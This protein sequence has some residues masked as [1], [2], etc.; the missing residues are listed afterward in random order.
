M[1]TQTWVDKA[2]G[3]NSAHIS[4]EHFVLPGYGD[5]GPTLEIFSYED[6]PEHLEIAPNTPGF[7]HIAFTVDD[8]TATVQAIL[9]LGG[10][11]VGKLTA[12][13]IPARELSPFSI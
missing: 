3:L 2:T 8:V 4:G 11:A 12:R 10:S 13:D 9:E 6:M 7:G 5:V 1:F